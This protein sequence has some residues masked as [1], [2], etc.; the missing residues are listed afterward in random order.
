MELNEKKNRIQDDAIEK[1]I[2][3]GKRG[4]VEA[5]TGIGK[6]FIFL[7]ALMTMPKHQQ[8][9]VHLF[10]AETTARDRDLQEQIK[11]F[12][13]IY[14]V[15]VLA[16]YN[17][18]FHCYQEVYKWK[19]YK[20]GLVGC[21]EIHEQLTPE[22]IKF[23]IYNKYDAV[24]GLTALLKSEQ[25]YT[26]KKDL[27]LRNFFGK[28]MINKYEMIA[29]IAPICFKY[30]VNQGQLDNTSRKL[31]IYVIQNKLDSVNKNVL[32]GAKHSPFYQTE[33]SAYSY[34]TKLFNEAVNL[35][36]KENEDWVRF[37][38][39]RQLKIIQASNKRSNI[40]YNLLSKVCIIKVLL[41]NIKT[42]SIVFGTSLESLKKITPNIVSSLNS[43]S[44]NN[45]ILNNFEKDII[46]VIGSFKK[47]VQGANLPDLDNCFIMS[48]YSSQVKLIQMMGR[49]RQNKDKVGNV[50]IIVTQGT[51]EV[52][53]FNKMIQDVT[54]YNIIYCDGVQDCLTKYRDNAK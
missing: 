37:E 4:T 54:D 48:Y 40:L 42:K 50:F 26:I 11:V 6:M 34:A 18:Q 10:L 46:T 2:Y 27:P 39:K 23:H 17:L 5:I 38:E 44:V 1:W 53:W 28:D 22:Y 8:D 9:T 30:T 16:M 33:A 52:V 21:D 19:N 32:G 41:A 3:L 47:L 25:Y 29:K 49:L 45:V 31:N 43:D 15:D 24:I 13:K 14:N 7:K 51:Q 12:N 36:P 35:E 20:F